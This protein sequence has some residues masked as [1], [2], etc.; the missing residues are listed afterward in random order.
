VSP[1]QTTTVVLDPM[2]DVARS[3][4][5]IEDWLLFAEPDTFET[6]IVV[7]AGAAA[8]GATGLAVAEAFEAAPSLYA[9]EGDAELA[10]LA[11]VSGDLRGAVAAVHRALCALS[12]AQPPSGTLR[13]LD[14]LSRCAVCSRSEDGAALRAVA[15]P[16]A[17]SLRLSP[18]AYGAYERFARAVLVDPLDRFAALPPRSTPPCSDAVP[19][20][21]SGRE[22]GL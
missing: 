1:A 17:G 13:A 6:D 12:D 5:R 20:A 8:A 19:E 4:G 9:P 14:L 3:L 11:V 2:G 21:A 15:K 22:V 10:P 7:R 16:A 18:E